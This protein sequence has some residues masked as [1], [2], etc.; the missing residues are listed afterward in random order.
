MKY[1][2]RYYQPRK[3]LGL[4]KTELGYSSWVNGYGY[5]VFT[6]ENEKAIYDDINVAYAT[7]EAH[8]RLLGSKENFYRVEEIE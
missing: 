5:C 8:Q 7:I 6:R 2:V 1:G 4:V 3:I